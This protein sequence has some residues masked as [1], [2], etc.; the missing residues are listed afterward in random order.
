MSLVKIICFQALIA[1]FWFEFT[2]LREKAP[3][4]LSISNSTLQPVPRSSA[5][6]C[7]HAYLAVVSRILPQRIGLTLRQEWRDDHEAKRLLILERPNRT[8]PIRARFCQV[9]GSSP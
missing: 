7:G 8:K 1:L 3:L 4:V 6:I 5:E 2:E 9:H